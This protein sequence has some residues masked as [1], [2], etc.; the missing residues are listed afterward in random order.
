M[1]NL[2]LLKNRGIAYLALGHLHTYQTGRLSD[3]GI[4]C[5]PGCLEGRGFDE[6]GEKGFVLLTVEGGSVAHEFVP[7]SAR[8][9]HR[10]QTDI[11]GL[12]QNAQIAQRMREQARG[13]SPEDMVEFLLTGESCPTADISAPYLQQ[14]LQG[15][16]FFV[17]VK[18][19]SHLALDADAYRNDV[20]LKGEFI[21]QVLASELTDA[22]KAAVIRAGLQALSGEE[23]S[24]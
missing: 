3:G 12:T 1:I 24:L 23:I 6:C 11:T 18:D 14:T 15:S 20:S 8:Q 13:L 5:Y 21:R 7:F 22:D 17:K 16:F 2:N 19:E 9:L 10:V 4:Y